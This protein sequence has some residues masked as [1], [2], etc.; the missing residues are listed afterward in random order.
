MG[1]LE[2]VLHVLKVA[3]SSQGLVF[4]NTSFQAARISPQTPRAV[5]FNDDVYV[6][7]VQGGAVLEVAAVD[8]KAGA[9]FYSLPQG[10]TDRPRFVRQTSACLQCHESPHTGNVPGFLMRSVYPGADG[11]PVYSAGT[12]VTTDQSPFQERWGGWYADGE[13]PGSSMANGVANDAAHPEHLFR[14]ARPLSEEIDASPYLTPHS[15]P[16]ALMV[17]AHQTRLHNLLARANSETTRALA[18]DALLRNILRLRDGKRSETFEVRL[19]AACEPVVEG[20]LFSGEAPIPAGLT[21]STE[22]TREFE[23]LGPR[24]ALGRSLRQFDL[25]GR[26]FKFPCSYLIYSEQFDALPEQAR[27]YI[28]RRLWQVL[29]GRDDSAAF[30]RLSDGARDSIYQILSQTKAGLPAYWK[31]R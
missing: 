3:P 28:Y 10:K 13:V 22:F 20:L 14:E 29:T 15:D 27:Q 18:D 26:L 9:V 30:S 8:P 21:G 16:V 6:G 7:W 1:G 31:P 2:S 11:T 5:Y 17:L 19:K 24:D 12:F 23:R 4:S 25:T